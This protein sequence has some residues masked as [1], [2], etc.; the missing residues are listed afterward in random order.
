VRGT[1]DAVATGKALSPEDDAALRKHLRECDA[2]RGHYDRTVGVLRLARGGAEAW[3][4]G[5]AQRMTARAVAIAGNP[6]ARPFPRWRVAV[7]GV[8]V[9]VGA[10]I[11]VVA[12]PREP[13]GRVLI[14][15][16]GFTVDGKPAAKDQ[17]VLEDAV[18]ATNEADSTV[19]LE[20][21]QGRRA[22]L[23][24]PGTRVRV[25][26]AGRLALETGRVRVQLKVGTPFVVATPEGASASATGGIFVAEHRGEGTL[27]AVHQGKVDVQSGMHAVT[28]REG[29]ETTVGVS[30]QR[31][32]VRAASANALVED[33][34]DGSVWGAILRFLRSV[35]EAIGRALSSD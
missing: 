17:V 16:A 26:S 5:E 24:R 22:V 4:P 28:V 32:P 23:L 8:A 27:V 29:E 33:R 13:V 10:V 20:N 31:S 15:G 6:P 12:W 30:G 1:I 34:G 25:T 7:A 3:A 2:C 11:A 9:A 14:A 19:L 18:L 21:A 35:V